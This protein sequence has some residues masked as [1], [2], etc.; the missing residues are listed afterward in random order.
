MAFPKI[1]TVRLSGC[2]QVQPVSLETPFCIR[3]LS[4]TWIDVPEC[5]HLQPVLY[6]EN[7]YWGDHLRAIN[8]QAWVFRRFFKR[9]TF[10]YKRARLRF[11]AIDYFAEVW[12]NERFAGQHEG[13][14]NPFDLDVTSLLDGEADVSL[15]VRVSAPWDAPNPHGTYPTD[16]VIRGLVKGLYEHGEGVIP[17]NVNPIGIWRPVW[18]ILDQGVSIDHVRIRT[19]LSGRIDLQVTITNSTNE[20]WQGILVLCIEADN[21]DGGGVNVCRDLS[22]PSGTHVLDLT[23]QIPDVH[24]WWAWDHGPPDLYRLNA[25]LLDRDGSTISQKQERFGIRTVRLERS[26]QR[27][28]YWLNERPIAIRGTSYMP[29]L[30]LSECNENTLASDLA[31]ARDGNLNLLRVHVHVSPPELYDLCDATGMLIWQDFELNWIQDS[32]VEFERRARALQREMIDMLGNHPSI[33]TWACHNEPTM[34]LT[35]RQNLEKRPDPALYADACQQDPTRPVFICSGQLED[36]WRRSGDSHWY[37]GAI[38]SRHYTDIYAHYTRLNTEF[39]FEAPAAVETLRAYPEVWQRLQHLEGQI[40]HLWAYQAALIQYQVE[41]FRR[42]RAGYIHF[43]LVDLVPQVGCG[44]LDSCRVPKSG[45]AALRR[46]SQPLLPALEHEGRKPIALWI[47]NDTPCEYPNATLCWRVA[48]PDGN[49]LLEGEKTLDIGANQSQPVLPIRWQVAPAD[50]ARI[51]LR[52]FSS[53]G[54]LLSENEYVEPFR[55]LRRP[56]GYPWKFDP[57]LGTKV[58]DRPDAPSL[59]AQNS[60]ALLKLI[61]LSLREE[62][63]E[64]MLR[65]RLPTKL[66]SWIARLADAVIG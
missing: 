6:P 17:P 29:A 61:P 57:Y 62:L 36:D 1:N 47:F 48:D 52:I 12:V 23:L 44:V 20:Q 41:H 35:R 21:H 49:I 55:P 63:A 10:P 3:D 18:L 50:C 66:V 53:A 32:S 24:L 15:M 27:F 58:F 56:R 31:F 28:T 46:A 64:R 16:H 30:Y 4:Q 51:T 54:N 65:R 26:P 38:W 14:F 33:I 45:Y 22:L 7:P 60:I 2:W 19:D 9:P 13:H 8:Q 25:M 39:G 11:E 40:E 59:A 5:A 34:V 37:Y 43:W 42:L